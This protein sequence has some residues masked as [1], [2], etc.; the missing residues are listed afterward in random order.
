MDLPVVAVVLAGGVGTRLYPASTADRPKQFRSFGGDDSLLARTVERAGVADETYVLTRP[1]FAEEVREHAPGAGVLVEPE[2]KDTGPAL[3][4][5]AH[6]VRE[7]VG[8]CV[9]LALPSD[10]HVEGDFAAT[11]GRACEVA[12]DTGGL[13]TVGVEPTRAAT[14]YGYVE[15]GTAFDGYR[16]VESFHEKPDPGAAA[17]YR[18]HGYLWNA[19]L[20]AW[21]PEAF[22]DAARDSPLAPLVE[23]LAAGDPERGFADVPAESVDDAVMEDAEEVYVVPADFE[24]DDLGSWD[25]FERVLAADSDG[26]VSLG[27]T[28]ALDAEG[29]VLAAG[30]GQHVAAVGVSDLVVAAHDGRVLV[31]PKRETQRV[32]EVVDAL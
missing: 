22:L 27:E 5:A 14:E 2:P 25:A 13:V 23:A 7:Q 16:R 20:F 3:V 30:E 19:G 1:A 21:R 31:V 10:H 24:W 17:R 32:R 12:A 9:M 4:Y 29:C 28:L 15:P 6:R 8:D 18:E 26:N 11:A